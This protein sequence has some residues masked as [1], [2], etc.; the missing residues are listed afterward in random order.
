MKIVGRTKNYGVEIDEEYESEQRVTAFVRIIARLARSVR[1]IKLLLTQEDGLKRLGRTEVFKNHGSLIGISDR[2]RLSVNLG[3]RF[4]LEMI[5]TGGYIFDRH[6]KFN[7]EPPLTISGNPSTGPVGVAG[8]KKGEMISCHIHSITPV[9]HTIAGTSGIL[10][11]AF[12][13]EDCDLVLLEDGVATFPGDVTVPI[14]PMAGCFGVVPDPCNMPEPW[15]HGGN[16]D[17]TVIGPGS[18]VHLR[19]Q[20][21]EGWVCAGDCHALQGEGEINGAG[22]E[23]AADIVLSVDRSP[24]Q[25][26]EWPLVETEDRFFAVGIDDSWTVAVKTAFKELTN[27]MAELRGLSFSEAYLVVSSCADVRSGAIWM[28]LDNEEQSNPITVTVS[29]DKHL[30]QPS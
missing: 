13:Q 6:E 19:A 9:G 2:P 16:M 12:E 8:V 21:D 10:A 1:I 24:F 11:E 3:E 15:K 22:L 26:L 7:N 14:R 18:I 5:S 17:I 4:L 30:F 29:L 23:M 25:N 20:R 28:M 27:L